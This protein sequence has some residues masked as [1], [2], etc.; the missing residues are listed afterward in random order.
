MCHFCPLFFR[1]RHCSVLWRQSRI[2]PLVPSYDLS[3]ANLNQQMVNHRLPSSSQPVTDISDSSMRADTGAPIRSTATQSHSR[4]LFSACRTAFN[5]K[6]P[7]G[8][9]FSGKKEV[10]LAAP[11]QMKAAAKQ[12]HEKNISRNLVTVFKGLV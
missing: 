10:M 2:S 5:R 1:H 4:Q 7:L 11:R 3:L 9:I 12:I 8:D 6:L